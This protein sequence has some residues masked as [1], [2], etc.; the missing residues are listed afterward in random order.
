MVRVSWRFHPGEPF[1]PLFYREASGAILYPERGH[2]WYFLPEFRAA[3]AYA[4]QMGAIEFNVHEWHHFEPA[5]LHRPFG[6]VPEYYAERQRLI[7]AARLRGEPDGRQIAIR[8]GLNALYGKLAQQVGARYIERQWKLPRYFQLEWAGWITAACR[9]K[10]M[11]AALQK[12]HAII[13]FATD[14]IFS[15][16]PLDLDCPDRKVLGAWDYQCHHGM[17]MVMPGVYWC[18]PTA[19]KPETHYSRGFDKGRMSDQKFVLDG[20]RRGRFEIE[21]PSK[22]MVTLGSALASRTFWEMRGRFAETTRTLRLDGFNSK[23]HDVALTQHKPH[24][25]FIDTA[26]RDLAEDYHLPLRHLMSAAYP[27]VWMNGGKDL[28]PQPEHEVEF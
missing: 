4:A 16:E 1:Y 22:R 9:A 15:T 17:T 2:G 20:W 6:W 19:K 8:L 10:L 28:R 13:S 23:R 7:E 21:A 25:G 26:P 5:S 27:V 12:P 11:L 18:G 14:G 24:R 3:Q